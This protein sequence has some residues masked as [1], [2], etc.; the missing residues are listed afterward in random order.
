MKRCAALAGFPG[1]SAEPERVRL[2]Y[3]GMMSKLN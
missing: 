3:N 2:A 1:Q